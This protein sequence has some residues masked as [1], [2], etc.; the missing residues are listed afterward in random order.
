[1][2]FVVIST[3]KF[4]YYLVSIG[5]KMNAQINIRVPNQL[6]VSA[7]EYAEKHGFGNVQELIKESLREKVFGEKLIS[8]EELFLVKELVKATEDK[9]LW[10][11]EE[12]LFEALDR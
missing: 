1:M 5:I 4:K 11:S 9:G 10:K 2:F 8:K 12:E 7:K 3:K 6:L